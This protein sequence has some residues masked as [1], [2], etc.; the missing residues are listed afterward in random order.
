VVAEDSPTATAAAAAAGAPAL[1]YW[2][3][4][5]GVL[6]SRTGTL[7]SALVFPSSPL[8]TGPPLSA[9]Y[10]TTPPT[11]PDPIVP[12]LVSYRLRRDD[13]VAFVAQARRL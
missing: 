6:A 5:R 13:G 8:V 10:P 4:T 3:P 2:P 11:P 12:G 7:T 1:V 9:T